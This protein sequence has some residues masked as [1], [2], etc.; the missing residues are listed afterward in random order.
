M[1]ERPG[2]DQA[3]TIGFSK[4]FGCWRRRKDEGKEKEPERNAKD[5]STQT[6]GDENRNT[7]PKAACHG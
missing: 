7:A 3:R 6:A 2:C 5:G 1:N 4:L